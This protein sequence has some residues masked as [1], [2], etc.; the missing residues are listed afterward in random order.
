[1]DV[2]YSPAIRSNA[3]LSIALLT[4]HDSLYNELIKD[5]VIDV[6]MDLCTDS[7][8]ESGIKRFSTMALVHFALRNQSLGTLQKKGIMDIF[9]SLSCIEDL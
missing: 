3:V 1:M 8:I 7:K 9:V 5:N 6:I 2:K 4:Y